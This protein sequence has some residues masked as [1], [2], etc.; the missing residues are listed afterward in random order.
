MTAW[1]RTESKRARPFFALGSLE[2]ALDR[3]KILLGEREWDSNS[4]EIMIDP[5]EFDGLHVA[6][7]PEIE[8]P[9]V[10]EALG[11]HASETSLVL[12]LRD[13]MLKL[14]VVHEKWPITGDLPDLI[15]LSAA[16]VEEFG[17]KRG[18]QISLA[19]VIEGDLNSEPGWPKKHGTWISKRTFTLRLAR[20]KSAV[21]IRRMTKEQAREWTGFDGALVHVEYDDER[22]TGEP[23]DLPLATCYVA[24][25]IF[26][27]MQGGSKSRALH[28]IVK[29]EIIAAVLEHAKED[30]L[31]V[32]IAPKGSP[33]ATVLKQL[34]TSTPMPLGDLQKIVQNPAGIRSVIHDRTGFV[35]HLGSL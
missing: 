29:T 15:S 23:D 26:D 5:A 11:A 21:D 17:H 12:A 18:L 28:G 35:K 32:D 19:L 6:I 31:G 3:A 30:I 8:T 13:P 27:A 16:K 25:D 1:Q 4:D 33:L 14:R 7:R 10:L 34:G 24:E 22:L 2:N 20:G 9:S